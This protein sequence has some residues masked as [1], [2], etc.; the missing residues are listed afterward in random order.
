MKLFILI[1]THLSETNEQAYKW[2]RMSAQLG[3]I[4]YS[5]GSE[6]KI[7]RTLRRNIRS[8]SANQTN[9]GE[10]LFESTDIVTNSHHMPLDQKTSR[11]TA[12]NIKD[13]F[14]DIIGTENGD[15]DTGIILLSDEKIESEEEKIISSGIDSLKRNIKTF[16]VVIDEFSK[17]DVFVT[18]K[19]SLKEIHARNYNVLGTIGT[20]LFPEICEGKELY[21]FFAALHLSTLPPLGYKLSFILS[22]KSNFE[23]LLNL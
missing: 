13:F 3:G 20:Q 6:V 4:M 1:P 22:S 23:L 10:F 7:I 19:G 15:N 17:K 18:H 12:E 11:L 2:R 14:I 5:R 21:I 8:F 9:K 16:R